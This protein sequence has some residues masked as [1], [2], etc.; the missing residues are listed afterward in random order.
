[1]MPAAHLFAA[2]PEGAGADEAMLEDA[3]D[4]AIREAGGEL[5]GRWEALTLSQRRVL[6]A[7]ATARRR[8][9][10]PR[11]AHGTSKGATGKALAALAASADIAQAAGG[12]WAIVDPF[13]EEWVRRLRTRG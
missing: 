10:R 13:M 6:A 2:T 12:G 8:S 3:L 5:E 11:R 4:S 7:L 1:M 9:A